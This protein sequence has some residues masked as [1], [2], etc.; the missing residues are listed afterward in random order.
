MEI[1]SKVKHKKLHGQGRETVATVMKFMEE[2]ARESTFTIPM[3]QVQKRTAAATG[4]SLRS[5]RNIKKELNMIESGEGASFETPNKHRIKNNTVAN[6]DDL[7]KS[8]VR[9]TVHEYYVTEKCAPTIYKLKVRLREKIGYDG[10]NST[11]RKILKELKFKWMKTKNNRKLLI[12]NINIRNK[13]ISY[14]TELSDTEKTD[15]L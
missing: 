10:G 13:R 5:I 7:Q 6:L 12:E 15:V 3:K 9:Q 4:L 11:L 8:V 14:L 1:T 2:G